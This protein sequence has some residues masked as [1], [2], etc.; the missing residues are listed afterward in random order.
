MAN[1]E[2]KWSNAD[3]RYD[4]FIGI[5]SKISWTSSIESKITSNTHKKSFRIYSD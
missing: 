5:N 4:I 1:K 3:E 2:K